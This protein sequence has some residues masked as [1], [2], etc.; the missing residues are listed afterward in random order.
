MMKLETMEVTDVNESI[1]LHH[2]QAETFP[3]I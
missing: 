2:Q 3:L 1:V